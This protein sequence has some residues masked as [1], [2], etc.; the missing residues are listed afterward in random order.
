MPNFKTTSAC[1]VDGGFAVG[2]TR[3]RYNHRLLMK[4]NSF[5]EDET[6]SVFYLLFR[7]SRDSSK[8]PDKYFTIYKEENNFF[9]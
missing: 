3:S 4:Q 8:M 6:I 1:F 2:H 7:V 9:K 5:D